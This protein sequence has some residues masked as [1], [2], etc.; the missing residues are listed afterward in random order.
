MAKPPVAPALPVAAPTDHP[1]EID[2]VRRMVAAFVAVGADE[3]V[4]RVITAVHRLSR[5]LTRWYDHQLADL[6]INAGE[7]SV[8]EQLARNPGGAPLT[9]SQLAQ[10]AN[11]APSSMTHRLDR[12]LERGLIGRAADPD[13]RTRVLVT[14]T[15]AGYSLYAQAIRDANLV[16]SDVLAGLSP[17]QVE[18]LAELLETVIT[19]L[20]EAALES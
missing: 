12:M 7:W 17:A 9:P 16:E 4:Q 18:A 19:G 10:V 6:Q 1:S 3:S 15:D 5:R 11:V 13:N 20:D 2:D 14:L 8:L